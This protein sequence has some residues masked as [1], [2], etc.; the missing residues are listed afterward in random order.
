MLFILK[1]LHCFFFLLDFK[2]KTYINGG[3]YRMNKNA[4]Q[5]RFWPSK[6]HGFTLIEL[7]VVVLIIGV[8]AAIAVPQYQF[9]V[10]KSVVS[11][12]LPFIQHI[13]QVKQLYYL[14]HGE[15]NG[16]TKVLGIDA[17]KFCTGLTG[18]DSNEMFNCKPGN[19]GI[20]TG[21]S[22]LFVVFRYC[23]EGGACASW[24]SNE[25][26]YI[27]ASFEW[28]GQIRSC[29]GHNARGQKLCNWLKPD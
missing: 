18:S 5:G 9:A 17:S 25:N 12:Y 19:V 26:R 2:G 15:V 10:D 1:G 22:G 4:I 16:N 21:G 3:I 7:L 14:E 23:M 6:R 27:T 11:S 24:T 20:D 8:L 28:D 13:I 29:T